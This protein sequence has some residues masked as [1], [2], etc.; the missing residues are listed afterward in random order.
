[1][2]ARPKATYIQMKIIFPFIFPSLAWEKEIDSASAWRKVFTNIPRMY[3]STG[4]DRKKSKIILSD[5]LIQECLFVFL[6]KRMKLHI[7][8]FQIRCLIIQFQIIYNIFHKWMSNS[9]FYF[10]KL[11][12]YSSEKNIET[13]IACLPAFLWMINRRLLHCSVAI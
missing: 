12:A 8:K 3:W 10:C 5:L 1:M 7:G 13:N 9:L 4:E 6:T 2:R 11:A